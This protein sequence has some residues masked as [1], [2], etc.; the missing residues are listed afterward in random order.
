[1]P[2]ASS[3]KRRHKEPAEQRTGPRPTW[4]GMLSFGLVTI[5]VE[6]YS[7]ARPPALRG[8]MFDAGGVRLQRRYYCPED[9]KDLDSDA[10]VRGF[11]LPDGRYIVVEDEELEALAPKKSREIDL[12]SFTDRSA[13]HPALFEH[14]YVIA[15]GGERSATKAY[16]LLAHVMHEKQR[17]GIATFVMREREYIIAIISDGRLL[18]GQ[19]LRFADELRSPEDVGLPKPETVPKNVVAT[20]TRALG[21]ARK[22][23]FDPEA[24][25]DPG[26]KKLAALLESK[27]KQ[28]E[29]APMREIEADKSV[30]D[31]GE[32]VDLMRMLKESLRDQGKTKKSTH[33]QR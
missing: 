14:A 17:A 6:L 11:E 16:R 12:R 25:V 1:M 29:V 5:P 3:H 31:S 21:A 7:A 27:R 2:K 8:H 10:L 18:L 13:L 9:D 15:P 4:S 24:L 32:V 19:T 33:G 28:H 22:K 30:A 26:T 20:Y 23:R